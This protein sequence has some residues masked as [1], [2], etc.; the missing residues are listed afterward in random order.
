MIKFTKKA[1]SFTRNKWRWGIVILITVALLLTILIDTSI[2]AAKE[3]VSYLGR[4]SQSL[5]VLN[6][7]TPLI[8]PFVP[9][10]KH[11]DFVS[12]RMATNVEEGNVLEPQG[13]L[14]FKLLDDKG[15]VLVQ[16]EIPI[17]DLK[18]NEYQRFKIN[19]DLDITKKYDITLHVEGARVGE[20]VPT[21]WVSSNVKDAM[22]NVVYPGIDPEVRMQSN[23][24]I[25]YSQMNYLS[26]VISV[27]LVLLCSFLALINVDLSEKGSERLTMTVLF[28][29]PVLMFTIVELLNNN[30]VLLKATPVYVINYVFYLL[31]YILCFIL[32]N[33]FRLTT[34]VINSVIMVLAVFN[35]FKL[36]W[37]GEPIQLWDIVTLKTAM[38]VSDNYHIELSPILIIAVLLFVAAILITLK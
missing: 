1:V 21:V 9:E 13:T 8:Q 2:F 35:Y 32:F 6:G 30:S 7:E 29:M 24:Q 10:K 31:L 12:I 26:I 25:R 4:R 27:F 18:D 17:K 15:E 22:R 28:L 14:Y 36:L 34:I 23:A 37:R 16:Q 3:T 38:N 20:E 5:G 19:Q 33:R 11:V